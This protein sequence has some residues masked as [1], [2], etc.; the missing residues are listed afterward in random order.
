MS[1]YLTRM[2]ERATGRE[3]V[4]RPLVP[5]SFAPRPEGLEVPEVGHHVG[6]AEKMD[7]HSKVS[8]QSDTEA[9]LGQSVSEGAR[10]IEGK[11]AESFQPPASQENMPYLKQPVP[12]PRA[13]LPA[14]EDG[15]NP[16]VP[17]KVPTPKSTTQDASVHQAVA[18]VGF[19][20]EIERRPSSVPG[21]AVTTPHAEAG[22]PD[23]FQEALQQLLRRKA[24]QSVDLKITE[25]EPENLFREGDPTV[26]VTMSRS[27]VLSAY[28]QHGAAD[29][30]AHGRMAVQVPEKKSLALGEAAP[31]PPTIKVSIGRVEIRTSAPAAV[32]AETQA[33]ST[34][35]ISLDEY[36]RK[37]PGG[38]R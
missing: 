36:L 21:E 34:P 2:V 20:P 25:I 3:P 24:Q 29:V 11:G 18:A 14:E 8:K 1:D 22:E 32:P 13:T 19:V 10:S 31:K 26:D 37:Q 16:A 4:V 28:V 7:G 5:V 38:T 23:V 27:V 35:K 12:A 30:A 17:G 9:A 15:N 6:V 33:P